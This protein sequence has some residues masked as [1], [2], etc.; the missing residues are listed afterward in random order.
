MIWVAVPTAV[1]VYVTEHVLVDGVADDRVQL[2]GENEPVPVE[3]KLTLPVGLDLVPLAVSVT[4]AVQ[5]VP[6][7]TATALSLHD[8]L[9]I[10]ERV[11][12]DTLKPVASAEF[13]KIVVAL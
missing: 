4:F 9:P 1:G 7:S 2:A 13:A 8:A 11:V 3:L 10:F 6:W 5:V 12:T